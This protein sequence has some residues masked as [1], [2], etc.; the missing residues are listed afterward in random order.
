[1]GDCNLM[2]TPV[3]TTKKLSSEAGDLIDDPTSYQILAVALQYL[4]F[5]RSDISYDGIIHEYQFTNQLGV[6]Q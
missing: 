5:T 3:D 2:H 1:M 6:L 4:T